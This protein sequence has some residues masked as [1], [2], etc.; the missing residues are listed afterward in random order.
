MNKVT[1]FRR[2]GLSKELAK[3]AA[4]GAE[5]RE[6]LTKRGKAILPEIENKSGAD[7]IRVNAH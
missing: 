5:T 7:W 2:M 3:A 1:H 4:R 6:N